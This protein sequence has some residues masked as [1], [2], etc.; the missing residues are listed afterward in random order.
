MT[1]PHPDP[2]RPFIKRAVAKMAVAG[3]MNHLCLSK[4]NFIYQ[5]A[6]DI[7]YSLPIKEVDNFQNVGKF[8]NKGLRN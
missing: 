5:S 1:D 7:A 3:M 2:M 6:L 4:T 8:K